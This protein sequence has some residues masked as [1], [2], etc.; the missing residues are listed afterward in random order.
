MADIILIAAEMQSV[1]PDTEMGKTVLASREL[2]P[3]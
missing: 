1:K 2:L 3:A